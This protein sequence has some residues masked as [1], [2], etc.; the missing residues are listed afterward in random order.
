[1]LRIGLTGGIGSGKTTVAKIFEVLGVPVYYADDAAK[2]LMAED[3]KLREQIIGLL[4]EES[5]KGTEPNRSFIAS[6]VF[7]NDQLLSELNAI[8]HPAT[9][10]DAEQWMNKQT[11]PY[12]IKEAALIFESGADKYLDKVIGV[13]SP[14]SLR[15]KRVMQRDAIS[16]DQVR[17]RMAHQIDE[18]EKIQRC[19]F[20][21]INDGRQPL[22]EQVLK[23]D[24]KL[25]QEQ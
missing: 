12:C 9:I 11:T 8:I 1:M 10:A 16:E 15:I 21:I 19:D 20:V 3:V 25:R 23:I 24:Q 14:E 5:Y 6:R 18:E 17:S 7:G 13:S 2:R 22:I 4:G